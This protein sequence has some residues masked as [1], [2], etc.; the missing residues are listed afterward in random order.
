MA[1]NS[2]LDEYRELVYEYHAKKRAGDLAAAGESEIKLNSQ[3]SL[4]QGLAGLE[5]SQNTQIAK[6]GPDSEI[7]TE[8]TDDRK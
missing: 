6:S 2:E 8:V 1:T 5:V 3:L 7:S 4:D